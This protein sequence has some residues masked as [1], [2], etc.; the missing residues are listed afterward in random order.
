MDS[1]SN[2]ILVSKKKFLIVMFVTKYFLFKISEQKDSFV[3]FRILNISN[4]SGLGIGHR[5]GQHSVN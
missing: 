3:V 2:Q 4:I 5:V 1:F